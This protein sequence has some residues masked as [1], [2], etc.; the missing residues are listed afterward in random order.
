MRVFALVLCAGLAGCGSFGES[1]PAAGG[2]AS[3]PTPSPPSSPVDAAARP[4]SCAGTP[5]FEDDFA[6]QTAAGNG[7]ALLAGEPRIEPAAGAPAPS[8]L[9]FADALSDGQKI[10]HVIGRT[11]A[12]A[13][14]TQLCVELDALIQ[15]DPASFTGT[16]YA[17]LLAVKPITGAAVFVE[18]RDVG[19]SLVSGG[20]TPLPVQGFAYGAWRH[21]V[22]R[23]TFGGGAAE[24][25]SDGASARKPNALGDVPATV[26]LE[27]GLD[28]AGRGGH[29]GAT[30]FAIDNVRAT[31][32]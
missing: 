10:E 8:L 30:R 19:L 22:V 17:E 6:R 32:Q 13:P 9:V 24:L 2:D 12:L 28:G 23:L 15:A 4:T 29:A 26:S 3:V 11:I 20:D 25:E 7:W 31:A 21:L 1:G 18:M 5:L 14:R 16:S 27:L